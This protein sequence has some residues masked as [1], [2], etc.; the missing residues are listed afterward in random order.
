M[1]SNDVDRCGYCRN[2]IRE[3]H[4]R[5]V[6]QG[7]VQPYHEDCWDVVRHAQEVYEADIQGEGG[8]SALF[9]PYGRGR[10]AAPPDPTQPS[11]P[12]HAAEL[13]EAV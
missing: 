9:G 8:L 1:G 12:R 13:S 2:R 4:P 5:G 3:H 6:F 11:T 7:M 10:T